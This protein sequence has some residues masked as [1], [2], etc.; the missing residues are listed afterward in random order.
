MTL[1]IS[2]TLAV[3]VIFTV[4]ILVDR[5]LSKRELATL[6]RRRY[7]DGLGP[8][9]N[10]EGLWAWVNG[11]FEKASVASESPSSSQ[12]DDSDRSFMVDFEDPDSTEESVPSSLI[13]KGSDEP[14]N[15]S[16]HEWHRLRKKEIARK[17]PE[18]RKLKALPKFVYPALLGAFLF[19]H[20]V[21]GVG[22]FLLDG[23]TEISTWAV[24]LWTIL[25]AATFG[26]F[27]AY[28][29][30]QLT[31]EVCHSPNGGTRFAKLF[32]IAGDVTV[33][34]SGPNLSIYYFAGHLTHHKNTGDDGDPDYVLH[35]HWAIL[36]KMFGK[37]RI[38]RLTWITL[39]ALFTFEFMQIEHW[40]GRY[41]V[42]HIKKPGK[43]ILLLVLL[44]YAFMALTFW[45]GGFWCFLYFKLAGGFAMGA[46][47]HPY[48][49]F[50]L[51]QHMAHPKNGYQPTVSYG[52]SLLW[53]W[54]TFGELYHV[55]H[56]DFPNIP[57][58]KIY[59]VRKIAPEYYQDLWVVDSVL[60]LSWEWISHTDGSPWMEVAGA[61][62]SMH[63][64]AER[65]STHRPAPEV[66][67]AEA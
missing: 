25:L 8:V 2:I 22:V 36:P 24:G 3:F 52:G 17:H 23:F 35:S 47:G 53:N 44:K 49:A 31:H 28:A 4:T 12:E 1:E 58:D 11:K 43:K 46:F 5:R 14:Q 30:Q 10:G 33:G 50:W 41:N 15:L 9:E 13:R 57:F 67:A 34:T 61:L 19:L 32:A 20:L 60:R 27:F 56:H 39:F 65:D 38:G 63:F 42:P 40:L 18:V 7:R 51:M 66:K 29:F 26:A 16:G 45:Y 62:D 59:Q 37:S 55:E 54:M 21:I 6:G 64:G 48:G